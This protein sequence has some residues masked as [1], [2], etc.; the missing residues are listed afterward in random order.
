MKG[1]LDAAVRKRYASLLTRRGQRP[2][3]TSANATLAVSVPPLAA[4]TAVRPTCRSEFLL[5]PLTKM[6]MTLPLLPR[7]AVGWPPQSSPSAIGA[8]VSPLRPFFPATRGPAP[9]R[10]RRIA[11][12]RSG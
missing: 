9:G 8:S 10:K 7:G 6:M 3:P 11:R 1:K 12:Q 5:G 2:S 4:A